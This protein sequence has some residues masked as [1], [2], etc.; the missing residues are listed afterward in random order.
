MSAVAPTAEQATDLLQKLSLESNNNNH[1]APEVT[2]KPSG[3]QYATANGGQGPKVQIPLM[4][5]SLTPVLP[6]YIDHSMPYLHNGYPAGTVFYGGYDGLMREWFG[7]YVN[8]EGVEMSHG[9]YGDMYH[10]GYGY[11]PYGAYPS[12]GSQI[13]SLAH[14]SQMYTSQHYQYPSTYVQPQGAPSTLLSS[15]YSLSLKGEGLQ[16]VAGEQSPIPVDAPKLNSKGAANESANGNCCLEPPKQSQQT[17]SLTSNGPY[18]R[19]V[20]PGRQLS[21]VYRDPRFSGDGM[22]SPIPWY[23]GPMYVNPSSVSAT[24]HVPSTASHNSSPAPVRN[25]SVRPIPQ[26]MASRSS[27]RIGA[28]TPT[29][30]RMYPTGQ[31]YGQCGNEFSVGA[32]FGSHIYDSRTNSRWGYFPDN[33]RYRLRGRG[34]GYYF[35]SNENLDSLG[36]LNRGPRANRLRNQKV[37]VPAVTVLEEQNSYSNDNV[38][39]PAVVPDTQ[40]YN[41][42]EFPE[43]YSDAKFFVI[44]SYSEDDVHKSIKYNIWAST[45]NGNKK[46]DAAYK[47]AHGKA[48]RCPVF[49]FFSVNTSGQFL[50]VAEMVGPVDFD[51]TVDYWQQDKWNG[52]FNLKWHIVKD[53]PNSLFKHIILEYN[54]NKPVTNSRDT[55]EVKLEQGLQMLKIFK[56]HNSRTSILDDFGFYETR[57]KVML[58]KRAKQQQHNILIVDGKLTDLPR[59]KANGGSNVSARLQNPLQPVKILKKEVRLGGSVECKQSEDHSVLKVAGDTPEEEQPAAKIV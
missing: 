52:C 47:E 40:L 36:E 22:R 55:Q 37:A 3:V 18:V 48:D 25:Q 5:R 12:S 4:E 21:S 42:A 16:S 14:D 29:I 59:E 24:T 30:N 28:A 44:K 53:V 56:E 54:D 9:V 10:H 20:L 38:D 15:N 35:F 46:L 27:P 32:S 58:E 2:K 39:D 19:G 13:S 57:Q 8:P 51:K 26:P 34:N 43:K 7:R 17:S 41:Q 11:S 1:D 23:E 45:P 6:E 31:M 33:N 50:G 49:L